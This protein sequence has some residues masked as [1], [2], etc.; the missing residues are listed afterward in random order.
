MNL[1]TTLARATDASTDKLWQRVTAFGFATVVTMSMLGTVDTL[2]TAPLHESPA[3][4]EGVPS[5]PGIQGQ[6]HLHG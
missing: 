4:A 2:A 3:M 6:I 5:A 1:A